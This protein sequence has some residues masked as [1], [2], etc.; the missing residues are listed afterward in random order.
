MRI[1][2]ERTEIS[3]RRKGAMHRSEEVMRRCSL[4]LGTSEV[5]LVKKTLEKSTTPPG[6]QATVVAP[7]RKEAPVLDASRVP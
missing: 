3:L 5:L 4:P 7:L 1:R 6:A 2:L